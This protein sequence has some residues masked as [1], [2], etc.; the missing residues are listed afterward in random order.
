M[1]SIRITLLPTEESLQ[2]VRNASALMYDDCCPM[3]DPEGVLR[4]AQ[5]VDPQ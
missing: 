2:A 3:I 5:S 1:Q 4:H